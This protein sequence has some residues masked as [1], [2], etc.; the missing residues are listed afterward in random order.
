MDLKNKVVVVTGAGRGIG[1]ALSLHLADKGAFLALL[2]LDLSNLQKT[3]ELARAKG[4]EA[5]VY[6][7]DV[8]D[9]AQVVQ[10]FSQVGTDFGV[11][12]G[13]VNNAGILRDQQLLKVKEGKVV[14]RMNADHYDQ[15]VAVHMRGAFLCAREAAA[16]MIE[17]G[18]TDGVIVNMSSIANR[19]NFGQTSYSAAKAGMVAQ[20]RVWAKEL[21]R[22]GIRSMCIAPGA[23]MTDML[24]SIPEAV[25]QGMSDM[26]PLKRIGCVDHIAQTVVHIF[27]ND[28]LSGEVIEVS[29]GLA[30]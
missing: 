2:D 19:G 30:L 6:R 12:H 7:C 29:G 14:E 22:Y 26:I 13:V 16:S 9:E 11:I 5:N 27:E 3:A 4:I 23:I 1:R 20:S 10:V 8:S 21:G 18:V 24:L 17:K 25:Q 15:V 28:Y